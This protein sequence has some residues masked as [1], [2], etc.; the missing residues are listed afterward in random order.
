MAWQTLG[1]PPSTVTRNRQRSK[2]TDRAESDTPGE[3]PEAMPTLFHN[4]S[5]RDEA[6]PAT[7]VSEDQRDLP[8]PGDR[9][10]HWWMLASGFS[11]PRMSLTLS[12]S[13]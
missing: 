9:Q 11:T 1:D 6:V 5:S 4:P 2:V 3:P 7:R 10:A 12:R 8:K 13:S